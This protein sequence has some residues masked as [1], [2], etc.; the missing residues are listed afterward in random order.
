[1]DNFHIFTF[2]LIVDHLAVCSTDLQFLASLDSFFSKS[3]SLKK[4]RFVI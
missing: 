3:Q 1:M 2:N 4:M